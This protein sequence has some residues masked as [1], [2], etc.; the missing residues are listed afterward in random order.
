MD[1]YLS[2]IKYTLLFSLLAKIFF[3]KKITN[4]SIN[5]SYIKKKRKHLQNINKLDIDNIDNIDKID[6]LDNIKKIKIHNTKIIKQPGDG[7]CLFHSLAYGI[8]NISYNQLKKKIINWI[9]NN[10]NNNISGIPL[11]NWIMWETN[12]NIE[13]YCNR[14]ENGMWGGAIEILICSQ[15]E[16]I[17]IYVFEKKNKFFNNISSFEVEHPHKKIAL[18]YYGRVHYDYLDGII[19]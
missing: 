11:K 9:K 5:K 19:E 10:K 6:K 17:N 14:L 15:I 18:L 1:N 4:K 3:N 2:K 16:N 13:N 8:G 12:L 7:N